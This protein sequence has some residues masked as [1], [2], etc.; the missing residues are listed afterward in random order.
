[1]ISLKRELPLQL[2]P[3]PKRNVSQDYYRRPDRPSVTTSSLSYFTNS[4]QMISATTSPRAMRTSSIPLPSHSSTPSLPHLLDTKSG[5]P[6]IP[7]GTACAFA[8]IPLLPENTSGDRSRVPFKKIGANSNRSSNNKS[9][10]KSKSRSKS[11][12]KENG[13]SGG[14]GAT[15]PIRPLRHFHALKDVSATNAHANT[16]KHTHSSSSSSSSSPKFLDAL[17]KPAK[18]T[19]TTT[20]SAKK[21]ERPPTKNLPSLPTR[22]S[23]QPTLTHSHSTHSHST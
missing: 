18:A 10:H 8:K 16:N 6:H 21:K 9:D 11:P 20:T 13:G 14:E 15:T 12:E 5:S 7:S 19:T 17:E 2:H 3:Q 23:P 4:A 1:M 22:P